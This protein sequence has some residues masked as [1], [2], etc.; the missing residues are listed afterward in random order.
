[1]EPEA[2]EL[3]SMHPAEEEAEESDLLEMDEVTDM[4]QYLDSL[5]FHLPSKQTTYMEKKDINLKLGSIISKLNGKFGLTYIDA[6]IPD[7]D[8]NVKEISSA[9]SYIQNLTQYLPDAMSTIA[10]NHK[11]ENI[12]K[13]LDSGE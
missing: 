1:M 4:L 6:T 8:V 2:E 7:D 10:L 9:M 13:Q 3:E 11:I 12:N 5:S